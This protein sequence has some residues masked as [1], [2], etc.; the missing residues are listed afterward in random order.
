MGFFIICDIYIIMKKVIR[1]TEADLTRLVK[2]I[3]KEQGQE[4]NPSEC[5]KNYVKFLFK[6][7]IMDDDNEIVLDGGDL[8]YWNNNKIPEVNDI[9]AY[10]RFLNHLRGVMEDGLFSDEECTDT[11]FEDIEPFIKK[12]YINKISDS[13]NKTSN[14]D[15]TFYKLLVKLF[16]KNG[17]KIPAGLRRRMSTEHLI[18]R[19][20]REMENNNPN[21]FGDEFEY[22]D[23]ILS[24]VVEDY[25]PYGEAQVDEI[26]DY[27]KEEYGDMVFDYYNSQVD[28]EF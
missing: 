11:T 17:H 8:F 10:E 23:N 13:T 4:K 1:L 27:M 14:S 16:E 15:D 12:L 19:I 6:T 21:E 2:R 5:A 28:N 7:S 18:N 3:I 24:W 22:A 9:E 26:L 25:Y 20:G